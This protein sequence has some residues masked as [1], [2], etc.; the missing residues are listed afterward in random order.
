MIDKKIK[1]NI[2][3]KSLFLG[4]LLILLGICAPLIIN[5]QNFKIYDYLYESLEYNDQGL[6][7][8]GAIRLVL[9]NGIRGLPHYLGTF[10]IIEAMDIKL[11]GKTIPR[12]KGIIALIIIPLVYSIINTVHSIKY[13][14]GVPAFIVI[15][16]IMYLEKMDYRK[17]Y[18]LKKLVIIVFLLLGAQWLDVIPQ[19]SLFRFGGGETSRDVKAIASLI[20][21]V[22]ILSISASM[23]F[24]LFTLSALLLAKLINDEHKTLIANENS[25]RA[26]KEL[27]EASMSALQARNYVELKHLVHDLKTPLTSILALV[28]V[29]RL[30]E[31]NPK[32]QN[33]LLRI[34]ASIDNLSDMISEILYEDKKNIISTEELF[35]YTLSQI[36]H[37]EFARNINYINNIKSSYINVNK[38]RLSRAIINALDNSYNSLNDGNGEI[39]IYV[40]LK[41]E[42]IYIEIQD[43]G[44]GIKEETLNE[45]LKRGYSKRESTGLGLSFIEDVVKSHGGSMTLETE[46]KKGTSLKIKLSKVDINE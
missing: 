13:D 15:F 5:V 38:I 24:F 37:L 11:H 22:E 34:E 2:N 31:E 28:S 12:I 19:L 3:K 20:N 29:M 7:M 18:F 17:I 40:T 33:Y 6:L 39:N 21:G 43:N 45:V 23:F 10:I 42:K 27:H 44:I 35:N 46:Y 16:A 8:L 14:F 9:L 25:A 32:I 41:N 4:S 36:S 30:M 26:K 1:I